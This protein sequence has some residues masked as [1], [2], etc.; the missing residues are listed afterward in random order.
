MKTLFLLLISCTAA[1]TAVQ[2]QHSSGLCGSQQLHDR[3][4]QTNLQYRT[5]FLKRETLVRE[6]VAELSSQRRGPTV[7]TIPVV[8]HVI[9]LGEA[10]G[11]GT[12]LADAV[13][14]DGITGLNN[15]FRAVSGINSVDT[16]IE[17]CLAVRD[18]NGNPTSG[19]VRVDGSGVTGYANYGICSDSGVTETV[20]KDLSRWP[21]ADY[22]NIWV[23]NTIC[24]SAAYA[25]FPS[26]TPYDGLTIAHDYYWDGLLTH[27]MGHGFFL[28]HTFEGDGFNAYCPVDTNCLVDGDR[29]CDTPP[30]K[31][32]DC[33]NPCSP[34]GVWE[35]SV[36][37]YLSY[38]GAVNWERFT[39]G[40]KDRMLAALQVPP[41][42][43]LLNSLACTSSACNP[44]CSDGNFCTID[45]C[46]NGTC[47]YQ[48]RICN[49]RDPCT[50]DQCLSGGCSYSPTGNCICAT[51]SIAIPDIDTV[52]DVITVND[53]GF[54]SDLNVKIKISHTYASDLDIFLRSPMGT[55]VSLISDQCNGYDNIELTFD[56]EGGSLYCPADSFVNTLP[57]GWL[58]AFDGESVSGSW[59][60]FVADD[61]T[62]DTG[63]LMEWCL[64][65]TIAGCLSALDCND[66]DPCT[67]DQCN[68]GSCAHNPVACNAAIS[69]GIFSE[70]GSPV[71][72]AT[73]SLTG[74]N[75]NSMITGANGLYSFNV[76]AG[77]S[78]TVSPSKNNDITVS[79]GVT[80]FDIV[81]IQRQILAIQALPSSY[82]IIA[83]DVNNSSSI[84]TLDILH[85]R[86]VILGNASSFPG[87][88]LWAFVPDDY[89]FANPQNPFPFQ[90]SRTY[91]N[92]SASI[93]GQ[94]F[95]GI[96]LGDVNGSWNPNMPKQAATGDVKFKMDEHSFLPDDE[97]SIPVKVRDFKNI[98][99]YQFTLSWD[100]SVLSL[101]EIN[102]KSLKG[103][104]GEYSKNEGYLTT[105]WYDEMTNA[106][107]LDDDAVA[108]EM[109]FK[110]IGA[111]GS[112][113]PITLGSELTAS[114]AYNEN[115]DLLN[116]VPQNGMVK[117]GDWSNRFHPSQ[118]WNLSVQPNPFTNATNII[119]A[120]PQDDVVSIAI[121]DLLGRQIRKT[122]AASFSAGEHSVEWD[123]E[124]DAGN[125]LSKGLYHV[126]MFT[127]AHSQSVKAVL[128]R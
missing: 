73:I 82:K 99:G 7:Y 95:I 5:D 20:I 14:I 53:T 63:V 37:N 112:F 101:L 44:P 1:I 55:E 118:G 72:G 26:G 117:V 28:F 88:R 120:L 47:V 123:G 116:I 92:L 58:S 80:T 36:K 98:I 74:S 23:V 119:F 104:Y 46:D 109:K 24:G 54:V 19:I 110:V 48:P 122:E 96:K 126:R 100:A 10:V 56:D 62:D 49:D 67:S 85:M 91:Q 29:V 27:E 111:N 76:S 77:G 108:F 17:F 40:Q 45:V 114:E 125:R 81:L 2:S 35:N 41:R 64:I 52:N 61:A 60:L 93:T 8:V 75:T 103:Y 66:G 105:T 13:I 84:T 83:A 15:R 59:T 39:Q 128:L 90:S 42:A 11:T 124:D 94:D 50:T 115:L 30:H 107:T 32:G 79:N 22:Y 97:F 3:L 25:Y 6:K 69:G 31:A 34:T 38:C 121:Y 12:N 43:S 4:M 87:G 16:Q 65:P 106:V 21:T 68:A 86:S 9:H 127:E 57:D 70:T 113:S 89:A 102:N 51:P 18:P 71:N 78:Y 33:T